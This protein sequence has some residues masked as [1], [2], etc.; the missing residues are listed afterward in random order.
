MR[1]EKVCVDSSG[2][3]ELYEALGHE[4]IRTVEEFS[5]HFKIFPNF[6]FDSGLEHAGEARKEVL[7][8]GKGSVLEND[9]EIPEELVAGRSRFSNADCLPDPDNT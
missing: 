8:A 7:V 5:F 1:L 2:V 3:E 9:F 4:L 6:R